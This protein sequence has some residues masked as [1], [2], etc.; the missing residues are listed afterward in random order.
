M[1]ADDDEREREDLCRRCGKCCRLRLIRVTGIYH[2]PLH[3]PFLD[4]ETKLCS[5]YETRLKVRPQCCSIAKAIALSVLPQTCPYVQGLKGYRGPKEWPGFWEQ[6]PVDIQRIADS[7]DPP[8]PS[9]EVE[10]VRRDW[11]RGVW[12]A[13]SKR[14]KPKKG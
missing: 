2:I 14:R 7:Y 9:I 13:R 3:C 6:D 8:V 1:G 4:R 10:A 12:G 5:V 11:E